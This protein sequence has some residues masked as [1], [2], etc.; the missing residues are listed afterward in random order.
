MRNSLG[1]S[2]LEEATLPCHHPSLCRHT[3]LVA[4]TSVSSTCPTPNLPISYLV[5]PLPVGQGQQTA[6]CCQDN[7]ARR[8]LRGTADLAPQRRD[9]VAE[10]HREEAPPRWHVQEGQDRHRG[11]VVL[12]LACPLSCDLWNMPLALGCLRRGPKDPRS[13]PPSDDDETSTSSSLSLAGTGMSSGLA[14]AGAAAA[15][16]EEAARPPP[17]APAPSARTPSAGAGTRAR[18]GSI[19]RPGRLSD[20][21]AAAASGR[22]QWG[23]PVQGPRVHGCGVPVVQNPQVAVHP[24]AWR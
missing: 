1:A 21:D 2:S 8:R 3:L 14:G 16:A 12:H 22:R 13:G 7:L 18:G 4:T 9:V 6:A 5:N 17:A 24:G 11:R 10:V 15:G 20:D 23:V 19:R